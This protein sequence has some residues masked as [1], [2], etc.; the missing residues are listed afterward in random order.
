[1]TKKS[2]L[3]L[4]MASIGAI[5]VGLTGRARQLTLAF[6]SASWLVAVIAL[7]YLIRSG[8][9]EKNSM[10]GPTTEGARGTAARRLTVSSTCILTPSHGE[11][12]P[13]RC[14][15]TATLELS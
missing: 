3:V 12:P 5:A 14:P 8:H 10:A 11:H 6:N 4:A 15:S 2:S 7:S 9:S 1:M 13:I